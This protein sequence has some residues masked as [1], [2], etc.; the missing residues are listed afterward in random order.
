M[1]GSVPRSAPAFDWDTVI[2]VVGHV[3][4]ASGVRGADAEDLEG[5][6]LCKIVQRWNAARDAPRHP[7]A[8]ASAVTRHALGRSRRAR[9][10]TYSA[11]LDDR[12]ASQPSDTA[13]ERRPATVA[14][15]LALLQSRIRSPQRR[16]VLQLCFLQRFSVQETAQ[17]LGCRRQE[18]RRQIEC[19]L[20][21]AR[22]VAASCTLRTLSPR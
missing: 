18:V 13:S 1:E 5:E 6:V 16:A 20:G 8:Y 2:A 11:D 22:N 10:L 12:P 4:R 17:A 7:L 19:I 21:E 9:H 3:L 14:E 15:V